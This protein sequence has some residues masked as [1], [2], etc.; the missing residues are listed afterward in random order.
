VSVSAESPDRLLEARASE[1]KAAD[2]W[3]GLCREFDA[4]GDEVLSR[5]PAAAYAYGEALYRTGRPRDLVRFAGVFEA[6]SRASADAASSMRALNMAGVA[7]FELGDMETATRSLDALLELAHAEGDPEMLAPAANN[8]GAIADLQGRVEEALSYY[9]LALPLYEQADRPHGVAQIHHN[10]G[11]SYRELGRIGEAVRSHVR[12]LEVADG[13]GYRPLVA[14]SLSARAE[15][16]LVRGDPAIATELADRSIRISRGC[17]DPVSE[18]DALRVRGVVRCQRGDVERA[19]SDLESAIEIAE[20][21]GNSL[22]RAES[23]RDQGRCLL[24]AAR[25][26]EARTLLQAAI[27][28]FVE[29]GAVAKADALVRDLD[30]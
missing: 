29:L 8:L 16:E 11:L 17:E 23:L 7:A 30:D 3:A 9:R 18:G 20:R 12:A 13:V 28:G 15:C 22:L 25:P 14:L 24:R 21:T 1:L 10:L 27:T 5:T 4:I 26:E 19:L 2:D 6:A